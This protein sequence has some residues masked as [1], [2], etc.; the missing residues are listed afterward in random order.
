MMRFDPNSTDAMAATSPV[1]FLSG[2]MGGED[3]WI[4]MADSFGPAFRMRAARD[5]NGL[6]LAMPE[7]AHVIAHGTGAF[8]A[9]R[10]AVAAPWRFR[11]LTLI[12]ADVAPAIQALLSED[13]RSPGRAMRQ[14]AEVFSAEGNAERAMAMMVDYF[15]G[16]EAWARTSFPMQRRLARNTGAM[17]D[18]YAAQRA[19]QLSD[20]DLAGVVCPTLMVTGSSS[21]AETKAVHDRLLKAIPFASFFIVDGAGY[22]AHMTDPHITHPAMREFLVRVDNQWQDIAA[23]VRQAA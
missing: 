10:L 2:A 19:E 21:N 4:W 9:L 12:D 11:S 7:P 5:M 1:C 15:A 17:L 23:S 22:A 16:P 18:A 13:E 20:F 6:S 3:D 8:D 14:T